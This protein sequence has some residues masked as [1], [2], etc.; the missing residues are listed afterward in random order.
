MNVSDVCPRCRRKLPAAAP[1][2]ICPVCL[3]AEILEPAEVRIPEDH[4]EAGMLESG[5][6]K[7]FGDYELV[8]EI[9][10]GGMGIV[11]EARHRRLN[12]IVALKMISSSPLVGE[13]AALRFRSEAEAA[14]SL[15]HPN[16]VPIY[17]VGEADGQLFYTM[18][19]IEGGSLARPTGEPGFPVSTSAALVAK[20]AWAVDHAHQ[21]GLLHRDLKPS[22]ILMDAAGEPAVADF[23]LARWIE[24]DS[25][26][27]RTGSVVGSPS[28]MAPEQAA[29]GARELTMAA[30]V[31]GL[32]AVLFFLLTG[33]AP[34]AEET[35]V[36]TMR[37]VVEREAPVPSTLNAAVPRDLDTICTKCLSKDPRARFSSARALAEDLERWQRGEPILARPIGVVEQTVKWARRKPAWAL[38]SLFLLLTPAIVISLLV[39]GNARVRKARELLRLNL[40]AADMQG[41]QTALEEANLALARKILANHL[42]RSGDPELRGFEWRYLAHRARSGQLRVLREHAA[43][44]NSLTFSPDGN[45]LA[46]TE[47]G[48]AA[49]FWNTATWRPDRVIDWSGESQK[50]FRWLSFSRN[51]DALALTTDAEAPGTPEREEEHCLIFDARTLETHYCMRAPYVRPGMVPRMLWSPVS[52]KLAFIA[53]EGPDSRFVGV[54]DW[55]SFKANPGRR[56]PRSIDGVIAEKTLVNRG[57]FPEAPVQRLPGADALLNFTTKGDLLAIRGDELVSYDCE[58]GGRM[59]PVLSAH[60]FDYCELSP[61]GKFLA[62][63]NSRPKDRHSVLMDEFTS[64]ITNYWEMVGHD[65][66]LRCLAISP[67]SR[68]IASGSADHTAC[69]WDTSTRKVVARLRGHSDEVLAVAWSP[70]GKIL[71]TGSQDRTI[72]IWSI[73]QTNR[74]EEFSEP[75][76][77]VPGPWKLALGGSSLAGVLPSDGTNRSTLV[78]CDLERRQKTELPGGESQV[79]IFLTEGG[80][81]LLTVQQTGGGEFSLGAWDVATKDYSRL[82]ALALPDRRS[83]SLSAS[84]WAMSP[85]Q[86]CL[87]Q[88]GERGTVNVWRLQGSD[89]TAAVIPSADRAVGELAFSPESK[90]LA[91]LTTEKAKRS[92]L[93]IWRILPRI[94]QMA[95]LQL[96][97]PAQALVWAPNAASVALGCADHSVQIWDIRSQCRIGTLAGH[98]R[99]VLSVA[100]TPDG[101]TLASTDGPTVKLWHLATGREMVTVYRDLKIGEPLRWLAFT[102]DGLRLIATDVAGQ[103]QIFLAPPLSEFGQPMSP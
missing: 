83:A 84:V 78:V 38:L 79:P 18:K 49:M 44:V 91:I 3:V 73:D 75:M 56:S 31:Y 101:R 70:D 22:N 27:T 42:P 30:D 52:D 48:R 29:G 55:P 57:S 86:Q 60:S 13:P 77:A 39:A 67:D 4:A 93:G 89:G 14:A 71:A 36:A 19:L 6:N 72:M 90:S 64:G 92:T 97:S 28:Y 65:G 11:Y 7:A 43:A 37:A 10:R 61:D 63:F 103:A 74:S 102:Q 94:E 81:R 47:A 59:S 96:D 98:R 33:R 46:S 15:D 87:A 58:R 69:V 35:A 62:G 40:Y 1:Q 99:G 88:A 51:S 26:L 68:H 16:I 45:W 41:A 80:R 8:R 95:A 23:G 25:D 76:T 82:R 85:D 9:A 17:E 12:R 32:G 100:Y 5:G 50:H 21:R 34:F 54:L 2:G 53:A 66:E 24:E 20:V